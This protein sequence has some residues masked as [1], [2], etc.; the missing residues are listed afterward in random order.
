[1]EIELEIG[2]RFRISSGKQLQVEEKDQL[3]FDTDPCNGCFFNT[4]PFEYYN[5][6]YCRY[7]ECSSTHRSDDK[8]VI[9]TEI[10]ESKQND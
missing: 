10:E 5:P 8:D 6:S 3:N 9:F 4:S 2:T 1:M 7:L